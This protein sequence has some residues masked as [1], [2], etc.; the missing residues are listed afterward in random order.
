MTNDKGEEEEDPGQPKQEDI[1]NQEKERKLEG[2][3][4]VI[5]LLL[6]KFLG[7][8]RHVDPHSN[9]WYFT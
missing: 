5:Q 4:S 8:D 3:S 1:W 7:A 2:M 6:W 9:S